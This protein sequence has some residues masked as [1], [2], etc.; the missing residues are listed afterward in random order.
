MDFFTYRQ[1]VSQ[2]TL[3]ISQKTEP[4]LYF[5]KQINEVNF[6]R[7]FHRPVYRGVGRQEEVSVF[8]DEI[9]CFQ[10]PPGRNVFVG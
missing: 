2:D 3:P 6:D 8:E 1:K 7:M 10:G 4:E 9:N 5:I